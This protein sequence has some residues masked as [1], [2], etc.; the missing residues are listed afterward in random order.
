[1]DV[2]VDVDRYICVQDVCPGY[3][4]GLDVSEHL[5][6][7]MTFSTSPTHTQTWIK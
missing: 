2:D 1:M 5:A 3:G 4:T 7:C 6:P